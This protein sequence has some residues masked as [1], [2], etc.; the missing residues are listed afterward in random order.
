MKQFKD[1][2]KEVVSSVKLRKD[3]RTSIA[4]GTTINWL[5]NPDDDSQHQKFMSK[6]IL[7]KIKKGATPGKIYKVKQAETLGPVDASGKF[8]PKSTDPDYVAAFK[9]MNIVSNDVVLVD[10][11][12]SFYGTWRNNGAEVM[13]VVGDKMYR[14]NNAPTE[15][16]NLFN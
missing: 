5:F 8:A 13:L 3:Y 1:F 12:Y 11:M 10:Y 14:K 16:K 4:G 6:A 9:V 7:D 2:M 15:Y